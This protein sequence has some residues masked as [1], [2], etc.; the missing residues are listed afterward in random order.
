[1]TGKGNNQALRD[2]L[3]LHPRRWLR[4]LC[5]P[6]RF[7]GEG[8]NKDQPDKPRGNLHTTAN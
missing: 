4:S 5:R 7:D 1:M 2:A 8:Q 6:C 3:D